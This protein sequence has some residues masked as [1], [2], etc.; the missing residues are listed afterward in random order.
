MEGL[1]QP[2]RIELS[3]QAP[4]VHNAPVPRTNRDFEAIAS[5]P[6]SIDEVSSAAINAPDL[7]ESPVTKKAFAFR[8]G[9]ASAII[10]AP[11]NIDVDGDGF[12]RA[13]QGDGSS[14]KPQ[15]D[16]DNSE[17]SAHPLVLQLGH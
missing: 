8:A 17:T 6:A 2:Q 9:D 15:D 4:H 11:A 13:G 5:T 14:Q 7:P 3:P 16:G 1:Q 12:D 10:D